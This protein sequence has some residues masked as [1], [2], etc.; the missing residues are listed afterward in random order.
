MTIVEQ[1]DKRLILKMHRGSS[2]FLVIFLSCC[3]FV[4]LY[5]ELSLISFIVSIFKTATLP[6]IIKVFGLIF[7]VIVFFFWTFICILMSYFLI[8][9]MSGLILP[10][11]I[12]LDKDSDKIII[13]NVKLSLRRVLSQWRLSEIQG[14]RIIEEIGSKSNNPYKFNLV[15][16]SEIEVQMDQY[17][18]ML[19]FS[20]E[21]AEIINNFLESE[22]QL[23][24][25]TLSEPDCNID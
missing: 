13:R 21:N 7:I 24:F 9:L 8:L 6:L 18:N 5:G 11:F 10:P 3:L 14:I 15:F 12:L 22:L 25:I 20:K 23:T 16:N 2:L 17:I 19:F 1:N 4:T